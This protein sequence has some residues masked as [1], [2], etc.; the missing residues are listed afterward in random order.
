[1]QGRLFRSKDG[2]AREITTLLVIK[3]AL[4]LVL[5]RLFFAH[6]PVTGAEGVAAAVLGNAAAPVPQVV[7]QRERQR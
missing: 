3:A 5:W 1:M 6:A 7:E 2:Y 4:L